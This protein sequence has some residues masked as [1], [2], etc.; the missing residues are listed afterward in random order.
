MSTAT[1]LPGW[2]WFCRYSPSWPGLRGTPRPPD[3]ICHTTDPAYPPLSGLH[4]PAP[5]PSEATHQ[6]RAGCGGRDWSPCS[7]ERCKADTCSI[8][9][10][11]HQA[12]GRRQSEP[13]RHPGCREA[14]LP[15]WPLSHT[16]APAALWSPAPVLGLASVQSDQ[17]WL[18]GNSSRPRSQ[19]S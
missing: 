7:C 5:W 2:S 13:C 18:P 15:I 9:G 12:V 3:P 4:L 19:P 6:K 10:D 14:W 11:G 8:P 1:Y 17:T 16:H